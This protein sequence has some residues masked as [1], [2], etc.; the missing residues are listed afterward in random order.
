M[1]NDY[2]SACWSTR[3]QYILSSYNAWRQWLQ[4]IVVSQ[5]ATRY[6]Q[7]ASLLTSIVLLL[8]FLYSH[9]HTMSSIFH[10][11]TLWEWMFI[12]CF[13]WLVSCI[14]IISCVFGWNIWLHLLLPTVSI[15]FTSHTSRAPSVMKLHFIASVI[16]LGGVTI[17]L[18][19]EWCLYRS[20]QLL[21]TNYNSYLVHQYNVMVTIQKINT[22]IYI[23]AAR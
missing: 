14:T 20:F 11:V 5:K 15:W 12:S 13:L 7:A 9:F 2:I 1:L 23:A 22:T 21:C 4:G 8:Q 18:A 17:T 16:L 6:W 19:G 10:L 3:S